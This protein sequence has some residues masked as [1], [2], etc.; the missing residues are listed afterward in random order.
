MVLKYY[1]D[2]CIV[3]VPL[4]FVPEASAS[5]AFPPAVKGGRIY[6]GPSE[7]DHL[8]SRL[9]SKRKL[10]KECQLSGRVLPGVKGYC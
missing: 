4:N 9:G 1:L 6:Q 5:L 8:L 10:V 3:G 7:E 2:Y